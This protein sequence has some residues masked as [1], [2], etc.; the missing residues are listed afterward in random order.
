MDLVVTV[1]DAAM[2]DFLRSVAGELLLHPNATVVA[3]AQKVLNGE[4]LTDAQMKGLGEAWIKMT[5]RERYLG[6]KRQMAAQAAATDPSNQ[7]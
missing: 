6:Y 5:G 2:P 7:W 3:G 1:P 4:A